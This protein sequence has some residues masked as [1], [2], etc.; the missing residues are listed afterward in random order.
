MTDEAEKRGQLIRHLED[1]LALADENE[2]ARLSSVVDMLIV[3]R[4]TAA[5]GFRTVRI[6]KRGGARN[7]SVS[8]WAAPRD[9]SFTAL[10]RSRC[11]NGGAKNNCNGKR[12]S[13]PNLH[14]CLPC[15]W[16]PICGIRGPFLELLKIQSRSS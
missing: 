12:K 3:A 2:V 4:V 13:C 1:A 7:D 11:R 5:G 6:G 8:V 9:C 10:R 15:W 16:V 14:F